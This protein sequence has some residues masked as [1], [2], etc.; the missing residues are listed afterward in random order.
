MITLAWGFSFKSCMEEKVH[1]SATLLCHANEENWFN[2]RFTLFTMTLDMWCW[3]CKWKSLT[4]V[5]DCFSLQ[6]LLSILALWHLMPAIHIPQCDSLM[7]VS[8]YF[9]L[10]FTISIL[11]LWHRIS[12]IHM[13]HHMSP[14][15]RRMIALT[16]SF[17]FQSWCCVIMNLHHTWCIMK[18]PNIGEWLL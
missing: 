17:R 4:S 14:Y 8:D 5:N 16:C 15:N 13:L 18:I 12:T 6:F 7:T 1:A 3:S 9:N 10:L 11:M 2:L